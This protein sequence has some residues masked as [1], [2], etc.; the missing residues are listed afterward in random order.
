MKGCVLRHMHPHSLIRPCTFWM[1]GFL[2]PNLST[3]QSAKALLKLDRCASW[4]EFVSRT[5][6]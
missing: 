2:D 6:E 5:Y 4:L 1:R 3:G